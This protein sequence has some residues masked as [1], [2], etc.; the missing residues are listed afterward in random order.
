ML[1]TPDPL[2]RLLGPVL[3]RR[4]GLPDITEMAR[5]VSRDG[6]ITPLPPWVPTAPSGWLRNS[7]PTPQEL[8]SPTGEHIC[9]ITSRKSGM[10]GKGT[11]DP[12]RFRGVRSSGVRK[13]AEDLTFESNQGANRAR[14]RQQ[15][16]KLPQCYGCQ[17]RRWTRWASRRTYERLARLLAPENAS[18]QLD[19]RHPGHKAPCVLDVVRG[20]TI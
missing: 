7:F 2:F 5:K 13:G 1:Q 16:R 15:L 8:R 3:V 4:T 9:S 18:L 17:C 19:Y 6:A 14:I 20:L 11:T 12:I 10:D